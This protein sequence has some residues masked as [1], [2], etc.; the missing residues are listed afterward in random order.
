M[1]CRDPQRAGESIRARLQRRCD[2]SGQRPAFRPAC[3]GG[4]GGLA[5]G[6]TVGR[7]KPTAEV[8]DQ[9]LGVVIRRGRPHSRAPRSIRLV[10]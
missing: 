9:A 4:L 10:K 8:R 1:P 7:S 2:E 5:E 3:Q 6:I